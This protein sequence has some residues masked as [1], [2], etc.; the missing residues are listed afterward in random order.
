MHSVGRVM[1][2]LN[3]EIEFSE[4]AKGLNFS[5]KKLRVKLKSARVIYDEENNIWQCVSND[6]ATSLKRDINKSIKVLKVD[7]EENG[8]GKGEIEVEGNSK[9][10]NK[11]YEL[12]VSYRSVKMENLNEKKSFF[13]SSE[14]YNRIKYVSK[15]DAL[16]INLLIHVLLQKGLEYYELSEIEIPEL[17]VGETE[18][19][20]T[21]LTN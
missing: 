2:D 21:K 6:P 10:E 14:T 17:E 18:K 5:D 9:N 8:T 13:L 11:E 4:V 3:N 1:G 20:S 19:I 16:K 12:F 15:K 7:R